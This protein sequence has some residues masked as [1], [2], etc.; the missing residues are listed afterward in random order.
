MRRVLAAIGFSVILCVPSAFSATK[1]A[2]AGS[3]HPAAMQ[4]WAAQNLQ[5]TISM[6]DPK[7]SLVVVRDSSGVP[8]DIKVMPS[9]KI[10]SGAT[11]EKLS[12]L[13][14]QQSVSVHYV[15]E[16]NGDIARTIDV[17]H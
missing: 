17:T 12:Q 7:M 5:G 15:P 4:R 11:K 14:P 1:A 8:F 13:A 2:S 3:A 6:V 9:T 10:D 16:T